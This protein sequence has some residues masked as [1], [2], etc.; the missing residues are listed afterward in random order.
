MA[1]E[2]W[3]KDP[4]VAK[5][6][7]EKLDFLQKMVFESQKLSKKELMPFF[8]SLAAKGK[9]NNISFTDEEIDILIET[10]KKYSSPQDLMKIN[11]ILNMRK[12]RR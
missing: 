10:L 2:N 9:A 6:A 8:M 12:Q 7:P 1:Q 11:Q 3:M 4:A 5:I